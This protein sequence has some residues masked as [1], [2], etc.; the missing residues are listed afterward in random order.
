M[1][2]VRTVANTVFPHGLSVADGPVTSGMGVVIDAVTAEVVSHLVL[3]PPDAYACTH[4]KFSSMTVDIKFTIGSAPSTNVT[5]KHLM[6]R[7]G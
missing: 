7:V 3:V 5:W 1:S 2:A 4:D 6:T